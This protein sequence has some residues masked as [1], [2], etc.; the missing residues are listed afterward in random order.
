MIAKKTIDIILP[1]FNEEEGIEA[2]HTA[3]SRLLTD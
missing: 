2:F 3:L 1:A